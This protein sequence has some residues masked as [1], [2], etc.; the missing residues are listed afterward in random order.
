MVTHFLEIDDQPI[1]LSVIMKASWGLFVVEVLEL[2]EKSMILTFQELD[3]GPPVLHYS[4]AGSQ[5]TPPNSN[6]D[7]SIDMTYFQS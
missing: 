4:R 2:A 6:Q 5:H 1:M 7:P 3:P